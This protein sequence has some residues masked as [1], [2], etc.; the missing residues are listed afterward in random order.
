MSYSRFIEKIQA[1]DWARKIVD[2][3][4]GDHAAKN[5]S[6]LIADCNYSVSEAAFLA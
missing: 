3:C 4:V 1:I 5:S 2:F 6:Y